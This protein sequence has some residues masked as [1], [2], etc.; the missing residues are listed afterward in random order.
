[1]TKKKGTD[2]PTFFLFQQNSCGSI[3]SSFPIKV[4][5]GE[6]SAQDTRRRSVSVP[7]LNSCPIIPYY[8]KK[9]I[10]LHQTSSNRSNENT[11][12]HKNTKTTV[13]VTK[14]RVWSAGAKYLLVNTAYTCDI[15]EHNSTAVAC[16][17]GQSSKRW[18]C[19]TAVLPL[20]LFP[21]CIVAARLLLKI[22]RNRSVGL[23][24]PDPKQHPIICT[25][26]ENRCW[27][28]FPRS[29]GT[30][31][32]HADAPSVAVTKG[33]SSMCDCCCT[34]AATK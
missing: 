11:C 20:L 15:Y 23:Y 33:K 26:L 29:A 9:R 22:P 25:S 31:H 28:L 27:L 16:H 18:C 12:V 30:W 8:Q 17:K 2:G 21:V 24:G 5:H 13:A 3:D 1:M 19:Y 34:V 7:M 6:D 32:K 4:K 10:P 14:A